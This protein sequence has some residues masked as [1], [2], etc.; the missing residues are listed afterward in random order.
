MEESVTKSTFDSGYENLNGFNEKFLSIF[1]DPPTNSIDSTIINFVRFSTPLGPMFGCA[2]REGV[3][4]AEFTERKM[5]E[6]EFK[7]L[8]RRLNDVILPGE[9]QHLDQLQKELNEYFEG[10]RN[11]FELALH[12]PGSTFQQ[13][14]WKKL[15][16]IPYGET[17][18][19]KQQAISLQNPKAIRAVASANGCNRVAII[20]PC[21][22]VIGEDGKLVGY[23][24]GLARKKWLL[25]FEK[26]NISSGVQGELEFSFK[27]KDKILQIK[28]HVAKI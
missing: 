20:I 21:H 27:E 2:T 17:R 4:L 6:T 10:K 25:N 3:C 28:E 19:Y 18:S 15:E 13:L 5:L 24:G 8:C 12:T 11:K 1:K 9:N 23:A 16:A 26:N 14:V 7:D 22:R